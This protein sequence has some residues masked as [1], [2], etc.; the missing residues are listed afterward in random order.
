MEKAALKRTR[1]KVQKISKQIW[2]F[3]TSQVA[4][5]PNKPPPLNPN[6]DD[7]DDDAEDDDDDNSGTPH[8]RDDSQPWNFLHDIVVE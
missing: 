4:G 5:S 2:N 1:K 8:M 6:E 3:L 7:A